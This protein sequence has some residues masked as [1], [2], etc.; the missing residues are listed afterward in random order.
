MRAGSFLVEVNGTQV[1]ILPD[2]LG[3]AIAGDRVSVQITFDN[4]RGLRAGIVRRV[5]DP[6]PRRFDARIMPYQG[7]LIATA[8]GVQEPMVLKGEGHGRQAAQAFRR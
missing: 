1:E 4:G 6:I 7:Q 2:H 3:E 8:A 5:T